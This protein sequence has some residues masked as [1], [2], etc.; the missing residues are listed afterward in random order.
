V[1]CRHGFSRAGCVGVG[2]VLAENRSMTYDDALN[3]VNTRRPVLP[4]VRLRDAIYRM[5]PRPWAPHLAAR[6]SST[7]FSEDVEPEPEV[8]E[9][10]P[11][12]EPEI[13]SAPASQSKIEVPV[14]Q[15]RSEVAEEA[16]KQQLVEAQV[17]KEQVQPEAT[18]PAAAEPGAA[19]PVERIAEEAPSPVGATDEPQRAEPA[20]EETGPSP[21][22]KEDGSVT[23]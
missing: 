6:S 18:E 23:A 20:A 15:S 10:Q 8:V 1:T 7:V 5:Y 16:S 19:E 4:H 14:Q 12:A 17:S 2:F 11:P 9:E 13:V 3:H 21:E 22:P